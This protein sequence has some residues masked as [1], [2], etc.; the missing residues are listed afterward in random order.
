LPLND[1]RQFNTAGA[2]VTDKQQLRTALRKLRRDYV[3]SIPEET[4]ALLF[5]RPP[6]PLEHFAPR[7]TTVGLYWA[8]GQEAPAHAYAR[9]FFENGRTVALPRFSHRTAPMQFREWHD[10]WDDGGMEDGPSMIPQPTVEAAKCVPDVLFVPLLGFSDACDRLGQGRG[11]YDRWLGEHP[12]TIAIGMA[13]DC[14]LID[15]LPIEPHDIRLN[16]VVT[17][18]RIYQADT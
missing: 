5:R 14:Q 15:R 1:S 4:K 17:P 7:G 2:L 8:T 13:W 16:A 18:S 12:A 9:W 11:H 6:A 3:E 10:P